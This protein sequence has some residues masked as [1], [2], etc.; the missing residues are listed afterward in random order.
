MTLI[1]G[2]KLT[3]DGAVALVEA[4]VAGV[5][6]I[7][8]FEIEKYSNNYRHALLDRKQMV[9]DILSSLGLSV[10]SIDRWVI[11]G[12]R[13]KSPTTTVGQDSQESDLCIGDDLQVAPYSQED[14]P[15][16]VLRRFAPKTRLV[17][18]GESLGYESYRHAE[19]HL[20]GAYAT[21][22]GRHA[23]V[24]AWDGELLPHAYEVAPGKGVR[25]LGNL[26][27]MPGRVFERFA[28]NIGP[29]VVDASLPPDKQFL[30]KVGV[31]GKAMAYAGMGQPDDG[32]VEEIKKRLVTLDADDGPER[33]YHTVNTSGL[34]D[35]SVMASFQKAVGDV[36]VYQLRPFTSV[37]RLVCLSGGSALNI[38]WNSAIRS[39]GLFDEVWVPPFPNDS[40]SAI[41]A[42][43]A[44]LLHRGDYRPMEWSVYSGPPA[45]EFKTPS[46]WSRKSCSVEQL[47][48]VLADNNPVVVVSG[49]AEIGPRA[50]GHRSIMAAAT[51]PEMKQ[52]LN[53]IKGREEYRPVAPMCLEEDVSEIFD[54]GTPDPYMLFDHR[55][56]PEWVDKIPAVLHLDG[57][58]RLQTVAAGSLAYD[59]VSAYKQ[60][61]G[62]PVLCNTSANL[63]GRGFFPD[64]ASAMRWGGTD[65]VW[66][67]GNLYTKVKP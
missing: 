54:P 9:L 5:R 18:G 16:G 39:S 8:S 15:T 60:R 63:S 11:D 19:G 59:I 56:R 51:S 10:S 22:P 2:L 53:S 49:R 3:H 12:W 21:A 46:G 48:A 4:G 29:F 23:L 38:K 61:T 47:A 13:Q 7:G 44:S 62:I 34:S 58:A 30:F 64:A 24:V 20:A 45:A 27:G 41:G 40:G 1:C 32:L 14:T 50:L 17:L 65:F 35:P 42:A 31:P 28:C 55:V 33:L 26:F 25:F 37:A 6:L 36:L 67:D 43:C 57:T 66:S 52:H